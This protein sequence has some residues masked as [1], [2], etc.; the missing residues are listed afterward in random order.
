MTDAVALPPVLDLRAATALKAELLQRRGQPLTLDAG[1][2][3][4]IGGLGLQVLLSARRTW[5]ADG[6]MLDLSP[7]SD[8]FDEQWRAFGAV[9]FA[10][11]AAAAGDAA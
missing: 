6:Q 3:E 5:E 2:V 11:A 1:A 8:A 7:V 9:P 10:P 4:R